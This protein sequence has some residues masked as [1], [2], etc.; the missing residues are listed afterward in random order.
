M[1]L[2]GEMRRATRPRPNALRQ[3]PPEVL[4]R[5]LSVLEA[6]NWRPISSVDQ[7][8]AQTGLPK[9]TVV[10]VLH[11]LATK[12]YVQRLPQRKGYMLGERVLNLSSGYRSRDTV[13]EA[14]R[15]QLAAFTAKH[16]WPVSLATLEIDSMRVRVSSS[17]ESPFATAVD[18]ARLNRR[19]PLLASALGWAYLAFCPDEEREIILS[20]LKA[21]Q[22]PDDL[23]ARDGHY[24][25]ATVQAI[26][27]AG[28]AISPSLRDDP[29]IGLAVPISSADRVLATISLRYLGKAMS[30]TEVAKRYL[31]LLRGL[32]D[33]IASDAERK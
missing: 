3:A 15:P 18:R 22:R 1:E 14:A 24:I 10:R 4:L 16:K 6:L 9:A 29:A 31:K 28:Y 17:G 32:A 12:G 30:E 19:V 21:S 23:A 7:V 2:N 25:D 27:R 8:A 20:L 5:G 13:V 11:N 26:R 33:L